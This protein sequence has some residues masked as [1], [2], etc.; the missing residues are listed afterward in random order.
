LAGTKILMSNGEY[1]NIEDLVIGDTLMSMSIPSLPESE[2]P[3][4]LPTWYSDDISGY[5][6]SEA[7]VS[8]MRQ[9]TYY[10][11]YTINNKLNITWEHH[12]FVKKNGTWRFVEV[13][14]LVEGDIIMNSS[15][16]EEVIDSIVH[17]ESE[18]F[19]VYSIDTET[20]DV[21]FADDI[22]VHNYF[23]DGKL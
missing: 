14:D 4:Y 13:K 23:F 5:A 18:A 19:N 15:G 7:T 21:Y 22:L 8:N 17:N 20:L 9:M 6:M 12:V 10:K 1:K 11:Y 16:L 3:D 2:M